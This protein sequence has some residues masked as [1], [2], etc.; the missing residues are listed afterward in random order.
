MYCHM[1]DET[2]KALLLFVLTIKV[3]TYLLSGFALL[4]P[5]LMLMY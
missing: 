5:C 3:A 4:L 1:Q 2:A